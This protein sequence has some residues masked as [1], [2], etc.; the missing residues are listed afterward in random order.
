MK[1]PDIIFI[2]VLAIKSVFL[3]GFGTVKKIHSGRFQGKDESKDISK[4]SL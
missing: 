2:A 1:T 3:F 4:H